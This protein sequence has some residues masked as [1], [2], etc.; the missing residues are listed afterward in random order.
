MIR[1]LKWIEAKENPS[2]LYAREL[3]GGNANEESHTSPIRQPSP[4]PA[5]VHGKTK[6]PKTTNHLPPL[7]SQSTQTSINSISPQ[8]SWELDTDHGDMIDGKLKHITQTLNQNFIPS[9]PCSTNTNKDSIITHDN[10]CDLQPT[11]DVNLHT[12]TN[13]STTMSKQT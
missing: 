13:I 10:T 2:L 7:I 1:E 12:T 6:H 8:S 5:H 3:R 11:P 9:N 4:G